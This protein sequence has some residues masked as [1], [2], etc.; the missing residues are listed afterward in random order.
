MGAA[1]SARCDVAIVGAGPYGLSV[2][3]HL[4]AAGV[5]YRIFG[6]P[7]GTWRDHMPR[8]MILKS[9]G[10]ASNLSAPAPESTLKSWCDRHRRPYANRGLPVPLDDFLAYGADFIARFVPELENVLVEHVGCS[11]DGYQLSLENGESVSARHVVIAT[12]ISYFPYVPSAFAKL[13]GSLVSH[14]YHH[15]DGESFRGR[16]VVVLGAGASA[17]DL[18]SL[19]HDR[20]ARVRI[21]LRAPS[22]EYNSVPAP[23]GE[24][25]LDRLRRPASGIGRGWNS[26]FCAHAPLLFYRLP[27]PLRRRGV[28][29]HMHPAAG[30]FMREKINGR[31]ETL[32]GR[33]VHRAAEKCGR[34]AIDLIDRAGRKERISCDHVV[35]ATGYRPDSRRVSF[36]SPTL[37]M[38]ISSRRRT[39]AV[40]HNFETP[41]ANLY[42]VGPAVT[43]SFGPLMRFMIGSE[44]IAPRLASHLAR[45][46]GARAKAQAA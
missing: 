8:N 11:A 36:L 35:A 34:L 29:N 1:V 28:N 22:I 33:Y 38:R 9:D 18:A 19:F 27:E 5:D 17:V 23:D 46:L 42:M 43:D 6:R 14:S 37:R 21:V 25:L 31:I 3:A 30:W 24:T 12:G 39:P 32:P 45:R 10:F 40:S 44:F 13:P 41:A 7:F 20:G 2:A 4:R 16:D 26:Y 15:R